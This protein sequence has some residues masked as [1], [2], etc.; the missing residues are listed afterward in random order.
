MATLPLLL[1]VSCVFSPP[2]GCP[3]FTDCD[4]GT[5][6]AC[7][8]VTLRTAF[9][10]SCSPCRRQWDFHVVQFGSPFV[11]NA[12]KFGKNVVPNSWID[13]HWSSGATSTGNLRDFLII[14]LQVVLHHMISLQRLAYVPVPN[15]T[16][17]MGA[18][19]LRKRLIWCS[20][21]R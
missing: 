14:I 20:G 5:G 16:T 4:M 2:F 1:S 13:E 18:S 12:D 10:A 11:S 21:K 6:L 9:L 7:Y 19:P 8:N 17:E 15:G 3:H